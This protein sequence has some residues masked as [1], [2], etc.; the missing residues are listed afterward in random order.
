MTRGLHGCPF[1]N[2]PCSSDACYLGTAGFKQA[3]LERRICLWDSVFSFGMKA[4]PL[5]NLL[6]GV[7]PGSF[8]QFYDHDTAPRS[9][10][11]RT[12]THS[13]VWRHR[14]SPERSRGKITGCIRSSLAESQ[15]AVKSWA[16]VLGF[17]PCLTPFLTFV[18]LSVSRCLG[19]VTCD[20]RTMQ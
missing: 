10:L 18:K 13:C 8:A 17:A 1:T 19:F 14:M 20:I 4:H 16:P 5:L 15:P 6:E 9:S 12:Q 7:Y 3:M 11:F 2:I